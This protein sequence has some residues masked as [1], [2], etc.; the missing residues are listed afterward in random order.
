MYT[1]GQDVAARLHG[2]PLIHQIS[3]IVLT[4]VVDPEAR[5]QIAA[6]EHYISLRPRLHHQSEKAFAR[7]PTIRTSDT[8]PL[9]K[10]QG[11]PNPSVFLL[12]AAQLSRRHH[13]IS[14]QETLHSTHQVVT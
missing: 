10:H 13:S 12:P 6:G 5:I 9:L 11:R 4:R 3:K 2:G 8:L 1:H 7:R 14:L